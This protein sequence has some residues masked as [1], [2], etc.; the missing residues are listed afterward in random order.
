MKK[1]GTL[2]VSIS[3][4][5]GIFG[6]GLDA[7]VIV[8]YASAFGT[9]CFRRAQEKQV[10]PLVVIGR[11]ARVTGKICANL[12][13]STLQSVGC[14]VVDL[15]LATTPTVAMAVLEKEAVGGVI[16][17]ASHNPAEWNA[18]KLLGDM[19]EFLRAHEAEEVIR[20]GKAKD[21]N[22]V[23]YENIGSLASEDYL[24]KHIDAVLDLPYIKPAQIASRD[25]KVVVDAINSV[26]SIAIPA[27]LEQLGVKRENITVLNAEPNGLFAHN[28]EPLPH[29]L[30]GIVSAV[31]ETGAD[32]GIVVDPDADRLAL[33]A[34]GGVYVSEELTQ[35]MAADFLFQHNPGP[36]V[37]NL[38]S[39]RAI[40]DVAAKYDVP[41]FRSAVG[42]INV[43]DK[44][45]EVGAV[46][47]GEGNGGVILPALHYGRDALIGTAMILQ[48]LTDQD[49]SLSQLRDRM[50]AYAM[51]KGKIPLGDLNADHVLA[52][53]AEKFKSEKHS[54]IDGL[55][56]DFPEGWVHLR[57]SNTEPILRIYSE[58]P[59]MEEATALAERFRGE[60]EN[61]SAA[62]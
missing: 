12:V 53:L 20:L 57:K 3:G 31:A 29:N 14:D 38:S 24:Q 22:T 19:G 28:P 17:S 48:H 10:Q 56:I 62:A 49:I 5:R 11:D 4:I 51:S 34:D 33:V 52:V 27:V 36:F 32:L 58:A 2:I 25:F 23:G 1:Q 60:L 42:E 30:T 8:Q 44:M 13:A 54:T 46:L 43:V 37:T 47:G 6:D 18:L 41:V 16:L 15:D 39:S 9:W 50:P 21:F 40:E 61:V 59:T 45:K 55:K 7:S 35:V 26:G